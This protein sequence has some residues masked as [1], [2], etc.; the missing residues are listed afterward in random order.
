MQY[1]QCPPVNTS[2]TVPLIFHFFVA[3]VSVTSSKRN[4]SSTPECGPSYTPQICSVCW[5]A[6]TVREYEY[7][8]KY[9][10]CVVPAATVQSL[11]HTSPSYVWPASV[12]CHVN[13]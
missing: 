8:L 9:R 10:N 11:R 12:A 7:R 3:T 2:D 5:P 1:N 4:A 6:G 13:V